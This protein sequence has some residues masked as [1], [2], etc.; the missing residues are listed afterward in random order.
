MVLSIGTELRNVRLAFLGMIAIV[1]GVAFGV[2][3]TKK[4]VLPGLIL[5][6][7][8]SFPMWY[9]WWRMIWRYVFLKRVMSRGAEGNL[10]ALYVRKEHVDKLSLEYHSV[11]YMLEQ[12]EQFPLLIPMEV[13]QHVAA[14]CDKLYQERQRL[15]GEFHNAREEFQKSMGSRFSSFNVWIPQ[16]RYEY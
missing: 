2:G 15:I 9:V 7:L 16:L 13:C 3:Y 4:E 12:L 14:E 6:L 11:R 5:G 1:V 10:N 8:I